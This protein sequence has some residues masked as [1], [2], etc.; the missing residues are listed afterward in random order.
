MSGH[1]GGAGGPEVVIA[2]YRPKPGGEARLRDLVARHGEVLRR[3]GLVTARPFVLVRAPSDGTLIEVFEWATAD[4]SGRA[5]HLP[6][7]SELWG[8]M[9]EVA[10]F[11]APA[12]IPEMGARF[13]HFLPVDGAKE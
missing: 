13:P 1:Q 11:P 2:A 6:A 4:A 10:D 8:A 7:V 5:H 3:E 12:T 9:A